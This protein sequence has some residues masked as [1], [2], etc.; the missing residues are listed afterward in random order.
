MYRHMDRHTNL[1]PSLAAQMQITQS[2]MYPQGTESTRR[3]R[4]LVII[5]AVRGA[6]THWNLEVC[7]SSRH[8]YVVNMAHALSAR[9]IIIVMEVR[10]RK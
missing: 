7:A 10:H 9:I 4:K 5:E 6:G 3:H 8:L 1:Y 2:M